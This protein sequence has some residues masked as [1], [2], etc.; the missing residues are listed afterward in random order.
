MRALCARWAPHIPC[1]IGVE[2]VFNLWTLSSEAATILA[3]AIIAASILAVIIV[4]SRRRAQAQE[5]EL[6]QAAS[7]RGWTFQ[8]SSENGYRVQRWTGTTEGISWVAESLRQTSTGKK[9][10]NRKRHISR[11][12]CTFSP[13]VSGPI[14]CMGVPKGKEPAAGSGVQG[15]G[16]F[17]Q[18]AQKAA[19]FAFGHALGTYFG[20][21]SV[22]GIDASTMHRVEAQ[23]VPGFIVMAADKD[24]GARIL[25]QGF[26]RALTDATSDKSSVLSDENRPWILIRPDA[27]AMAR[28][29]LHRNAT[30]VEQFVHA[31]VA[32][33]RV[34]KFGHRSNTD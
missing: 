1:V 29:E 9:S 17:V 25:E 15:D 2:S 3:F 12:Q 5:D 21:G 26:G 4:V 10:S 14:V 19:S 23:K 32:L 28:M 34:F 13:G 27:I 30:D 6:K 33:T 16:F 22:K 20:D 31:G 24:E 18:L 8:T 7:A 11:W